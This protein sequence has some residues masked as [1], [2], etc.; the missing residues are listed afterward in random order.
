MSSAIDPTVVVPS[1][2]RTASGDSGAIQAGGKLMPVPAKWLNLLVDITAVGADGDETMDIEVQWSHDGG[3]TWASADG[4][5]DTFGQMTQ[6]EGAQSVIK[7]FTMKAPHYRIVWTLG[8]T[9]PSFTFSISEWL[10]R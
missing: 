10:T 9:T 1:G 8:G 5:P 6:P 4:T 2:A 7:Q 3:A